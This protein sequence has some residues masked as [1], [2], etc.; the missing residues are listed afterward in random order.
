MT[1]YF[2]LIFLIE[3]TVKFPQRIF[4][5]LL[6]AMNEDVN[7][8]INDEDVRTAMTELGKDSAS[9]EQKISETEFIEW[10]SST[11]YFEQKQLKRQATLKEEEANGIEIAFSETS[12]ARVA[13][14]FNHCCYERTTHKRHEGWR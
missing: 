8:D 6:E 1:H 3:K 9:L 12:F 7:H 4:T 10:Y 11:V 5:Q 14:D 2:S 13:W